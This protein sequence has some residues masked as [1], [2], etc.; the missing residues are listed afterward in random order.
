MKT[1]IVAST[2]W[3]PATQGGPSVTPFGVTTGDLAEATDIVLSDPLPVDIYVYRGDS[4]RFR[5]AV[6]D[7]DGNP[8]DI[9]TATWDCDVRRDHDTETVIVTLEVNPV[10]ANTV[11]VVFGPAQLSTAHRP[12]G[13][14]LGDD[15]RRRSPDPDGGHRPRPQGRVTAVSD[16]VVPGR[17]KVATITTGPRASVATIQASPQAA[18]TI[19]I[20]TGLPGEPGSDEVWIGSDEPTDPNI[21]LWFDTVTLKAKVD[22]QWVEIFGGGGGPGPA[23][24][25]THAQ[26]TPAAVW[27]I[28]HNLP[29][30]PNVTVT[31]SAGEQ[32]EGE[33]DY[34]SGSTVTVTF[35][36]AFAGS[37][38][39]S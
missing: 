20:T 1:A 10:D 30:R 3:A 28:T 15:P 17:A 35:S 13:V 26:S 6:T 32:V 5:V 37:A 21:E 16:F 39:L 8:L 25:Y 29:F 12:V 9:S 14:G 4:G 31:D 27:T 34:T 33:I 19:R 22:G 24:S 7:L 11:E 23:A 18:S 38:Y 2:I 36:A